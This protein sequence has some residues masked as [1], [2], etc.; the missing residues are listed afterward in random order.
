LA[1]VYD[2]EPPAPDR[3][4]ASYPKLIA[5]L[6]VEGAV[7]RVTKGVVDQGARRAFESATGRWPGEDPAAD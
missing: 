4:D 2:E 3:R 5:A 1:A 7:F 6:A